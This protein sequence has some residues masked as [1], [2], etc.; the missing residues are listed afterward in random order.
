MERYALE[1]ALPINIGYP[2]IYTCSSNNLPVT[3]VRKPK[4][5]N[6]HYLAPSATVVEVDCASI[7]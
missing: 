2:L 4:R 5:D 3:D 6:I 7:D 1:C